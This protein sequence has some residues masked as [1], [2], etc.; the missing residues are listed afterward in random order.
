MSRASPPRNLAS[1]CTASANSSGHLR[2]VS[3]HLWRDWK[4]QA[5][6]AERSRGLSYRAAHQSAQSLRD[7]PT[8]M[9]G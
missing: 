8:S 5:A 9:S 4:G 2:L 1:I 3:T 7:M 6:H